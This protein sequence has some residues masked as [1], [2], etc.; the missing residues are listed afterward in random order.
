MNRN[1]LSCQGRRQDL[2]AALESYTLDEVN[3]GDGKGKTK[4]GKI[5]RNHHP[6]T[7]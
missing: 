2:Q 7:I 3:S 4:T 5:D 6:I 1:S